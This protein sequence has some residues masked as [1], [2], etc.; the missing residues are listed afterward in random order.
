MLARDDSPGSGLLRDNRLAGA[1]IVMSD[2]LLLVGYS[3]GSQIYVA[4]DADESEMVGAARVLLDDCMRSGASAR[5]RVR[6]WNGV[7]VLESF[8]AAILESAG[9][10]RDYPYMIADALT[11]RKP[12]AVYH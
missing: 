1:I 4:D 9:F 12:D 8:G 7:P 10:R 11:R 2:R 3:S 5:V 6:E